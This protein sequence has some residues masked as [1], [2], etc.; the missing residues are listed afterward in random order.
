MADEIRLKAPTIEQQVNITING[1]SKLSDVADTL[2]LL[3]SG[4][5]L[6]DFWKDEKQLFVDLE[7]FKNHY[8]NDKND[9]NA[10][11]FLKAVNAYKALTNP[12]FGLLEDDYEDVILEARRQI[13]YP[14]SLDSY[15]IICFKKAFSSFEMLQA[16]GTDME[17][18]FKHF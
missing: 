6:Q 14:E 8:L 13:G 12:D 2:N 3:S 1:E 9:M 4:K 11:M 7:K 5:R 15:S 16:Y 10:E 18:F 17:K